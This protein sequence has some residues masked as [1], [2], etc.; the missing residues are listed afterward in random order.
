MLARAS[1]L[2]VID[3]HHACACVASPASAAGLPF[4]DTRRP[5]IGLGPLARVDAMYLAHT[6]I[7]SLDELGALREVSSST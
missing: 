2:N 6:S 5:R 7:A 1:G 3:S 4:S